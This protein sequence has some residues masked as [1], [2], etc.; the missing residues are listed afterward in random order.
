M[1]SEALPQRPART[2]GL[3]GGVGMGKTTVSR[4]LHE[5][6]SLP[7]LDADLYARRA[8]E[9]GTPALAQLVERYGERVLL[10]AGALDRRK[11]GEILFS[12]A[13]ERQWIEQLIHPEVRRQIEAE[14]QTLAIQQPAVAVVVPLLFEANMTDLATEIWVVHTTKAQQLARIQQRDRLSLDQSQARINSQMSI[15]RKVERA[16]IALDN[17]GSPQALFRQIDR[18]FNLD[19]FNHSHTQV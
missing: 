5:A 4:Y 15:D 8:V 18:A 9:P 10:A 11:L 3:T 16:D 2:I 13:A 19:S 7:I 12:D 17:S 1:Q 6:H 14:L